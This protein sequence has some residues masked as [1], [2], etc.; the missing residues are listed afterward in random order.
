M[1]ATPRFAKRCNTSAIVADDII[2]HVTDALWPKGAPPLMPVPVAYMSVS[3]QVCRPADAETLH[4]LA[5]VAAAR[6]ER[7]C[8]HENPF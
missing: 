7:T 5:R 3:D 4:N 6:S 8:A 2:W 1:N